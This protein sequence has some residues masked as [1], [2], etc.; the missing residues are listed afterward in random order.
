MKLFVTFKTATAATRAHWEASEKGIKCSLV[1]TPQ[2]F[3]VM[4][5]YSLC[6]EADERERLIKVL[7]EKGIEYSEMF[8]RSVI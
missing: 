6:A 4:C 8:K 1:P 5:G 2:E 3:G 7:E